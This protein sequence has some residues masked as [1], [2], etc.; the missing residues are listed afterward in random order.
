MNFS[1]HPSKA[2]ETEFPKKNRRLTLVNVF[3]KTL[4]AFGD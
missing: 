3:L 2:D 1:L 4:S